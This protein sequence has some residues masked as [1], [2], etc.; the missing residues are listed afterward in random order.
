[1]ISSRGRYSLQKC[2][3]DHSV[4]TQVSAVALFGASV[5]CDDGWAWIR[6]GLCD[7]HRPPYHGPHHQPDQQP[8]GPHGPPSD[9]CVLHVQNCCLPNDHPGGDLLKPAGDRQRFP[10]QEAEGHQ[11][12]LPGQPC[13]RRPLCCMLRHDLQCVPADI[14]K[15]I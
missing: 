11:Q 6:V 8:D 12:L 1:M 5:M 15:V 13:L 10:L 2:L 4:R 3:T 7:P 14:W 9:Q